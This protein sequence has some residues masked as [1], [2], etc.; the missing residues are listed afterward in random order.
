MRE[1]RFSQTHRTT[2]VRRR[3]IISQFDAAVGAMMP[4]RER[5]GPYLPPPWPL[6]WRYIA[7]LGDGSPWTELRRLDAKAD[8]PDEEVRKKAI[9]DFNRLARGGAQL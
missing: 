7:Q 3:F 5:G 8:A 1:I 6:A 4:D 2:R 9:R